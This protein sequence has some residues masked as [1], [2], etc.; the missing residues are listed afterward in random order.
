M[1]EDIIQSLQNSDV[2]FPVFHGKNGEDGTMQGLSSLLKIPCVG[3]F[4]ANAICMDKAWTKSLVKSLGFKTAPWIS[5]SKSQWINDEECTFKILES[6]FT[7]PC[8]VKAAR[9]GSS[10]GVYKFK[11]YREL[12]DKIAE[13]LK[14]YTHD[15][16][17]NNTIQ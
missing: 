8:M 9:L 6:Q 17:E 16:Y 3:N 5:L 1:G 4:L 14:T 11:D 7:Y 13:I 15:I 10:L 12:Q 2:F